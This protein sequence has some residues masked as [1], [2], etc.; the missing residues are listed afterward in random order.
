MARTIAISSDREVYQSISRL[1]KTFKENDSKQEFI[2]D[3]KEI[4]SN[5]KEGIS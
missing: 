4:I 2:R 1:V 3:I 5:L